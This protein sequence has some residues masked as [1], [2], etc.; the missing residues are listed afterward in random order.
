MFSLYQMLCKYLLESQCGVKLQ[1][2]LQQVPTMGNMGVNAASLPFSSGGGVIA[3]PVAQLA[4]TRIVVSNP[5][6]P[7][8]SFPTSRLLS[9]LQDDT[10]AELS[11]HLR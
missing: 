1:Y 4:S 3:D 6:V 10:P 2:G 9:W 7:Q 5:I 8:V 11:S